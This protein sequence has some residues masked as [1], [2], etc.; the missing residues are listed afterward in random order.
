LPKSDGTLASYEKAAILNALELSGGN[1][2]KASK[3]LKI[4]EATLY[5]KIAGYHIKYETPGKSGQ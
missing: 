4:G 3:I 5:R 1:R 2:K